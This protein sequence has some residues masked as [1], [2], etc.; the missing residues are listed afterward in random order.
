M[1]NEKVHFLWPLNCCNL[2]SNIL[3]GVPSHGI[4]Q[5]EQQQQQSSMS[6]YSPQD[7]AEG[8]D[9]G[10]GRA[11]AGSGLRF[12]TSGRF[13]D[14]VVPPEAGTNLAYLS[15]REANFLR[16]LKK[17]Q[18]QKAVDAAPEV[19]R[20]YHESSLYGQ[21]ALSLKVRTALRSGYLGLLIHSL[22]GIGAAL[23]GILY[24]YASYH[25]EDIP[26]WTSRAQNA[27]SIFFTFDYAL[28]LF[29][30]NVRMHYATSVGGIVDVLSII[31]L[32]LVFGWLY[33]LMHKVGI[34]GSNLEQRLLLLIVSTF[35]MVF[36][37][38]GL[39]QWVEL[40]SNGDYIEF[41]EC[42]Y[43]VWVTISTVGY[44]DVT[45]HS[46]WGR[47]VG[48]LTILLALV[49]LPYQLSNL[50]SLAATR[51]YGGKF[52]VNKVDNSQ[53]VIISG[54]ISY[55]TIDTFL[56]E[57]YR[58]THDKELQG[59]ID[60]THPL[61]TIILAPFR[62]SYQL[63][64]LVAR[65]NGLV[66][67]FEGTPIKQADLSRVSVRAA[68]AV[69]LLADS[70]AEDPAAEDS[71]QVVR[72]LSVFRYC[73]AASRI[74]VEV[75]QPETETSAVWGGIAGPSVE[76]VC[77]VKGLS[78]FLVNLFMSEVDLGFPDDHYMAEY[79]QSLF[80]E[81][82]PLLL[83]P[84]FHGLT[85]EE[86]AEFLMV[87]WGVVIFG[88]DTPVPD[89]TAREG[90]GKR[91]VLLYPQ[92]RRVAPRDVGLVII[93][94]LS[95][96]FQI[97]SFG[98]PNKLDACMQRLGCSR[99][100]VLQSAA[101]ETVLREVH[102]SWRG[103]KVPSSQSARELLS[104][105]A[106][107]SRSRGGAPPALNSP[108]SGV[109]ADML[110]DSLKSALVRASSS[111][112]LPPEPP[113]GGGGGPEVQPE[114]AEQ[115]TPHHVGA[116]EKQGNAGEAAHLEL[117]DHQQQGKR[118]ASMTR[119]VSIRVSSSGE[120]HER[121]EAAT[122]ESAID[123][124][125][126]WPPADK[127][128]RPYPFAL[129]QQAGKILANLEERRRNIGTEGRRA[130]PEAAAERLWAVGCGGGQQNEWP[131][132]LYY[133]LSTL[134]SHHFLRKP[135]VILHP[136]APTAQQWGYCG[137]FPDVF[138]VEGSPMHELDLLRAGILQA[139]KVVVVADAGNPKDSGSGVAAQGEEL[140]FPNNAYINDVQNMIIAANCEDLLPAGGHSK[141]LVEMQHSTS[142]LYLPPQLELSQNRIKE[143]DWEFDREPLLHFAPPFIEGKVFCS[144]RS[145]F[146]NRATKD[147]VEQLI[148]GGPAPDV[149]HQHG[150]RE[151]GSPEPARS[152]EQICV[153]SEFHGSTYIELFKYL[154]RE[155]GLLS[156]GLF[157]AAGTLD[158]PV[159]YVYTNPH[160]QVIV[161]RE[162]LV[163]VII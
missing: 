76:V 132:N 9:D 26:G 63:E 138:F 131:T 158:A 102:D 143:K 105:L 66:E 91:Q 61:R 136:H 89:E 98:T 1:V 139:L 125:M 129:T 30:E 3:G 152:L 117:Q 37:D 4:P 118:Q 82:H 151:D 44:G 20:T 101:I 115:T 39:V 19:L 119:R 100:A 150:A 11:G 64:G 144:S 104:R 97:S 122:L 71:A 137:M 33:P 145:M 116:D 141:V 84:A 134:R 109:T 15:E 69:Y 112:H 34:R 18:R 88:L 12:T 17:R 113:L 14:H 62:P 155:E 46:F 85:F 41:Y 110:Q 10:G 142:F 52:A 65:Y 128:T 75:L 2:V 156:L 107:E 54:S 157:R 108:S 59:Y 81:V 146:H 86:V 36:I 23:S 42:V 163:F 7:D 93:R 80:N 96:A 56:S 83:P 22:E 106:E 149:I 147:I 29:S 60:S 135:V 72:A 148:C 28:T 51:P 120:P 31:P 126:A 130:L 133:M 114:E 124:L 68:S 73:G 161:S 74:I 25:L 45:P 5:R 121:L 8:G 48:M 162:D 99:S 154:L 77:Y 127:K 58:L 67:F 140:K 47:L 103:A 123:R 32:I 50:V 53:Y 70:A 38:A 49:V 159:P 111:A 43:F 55:E 94:D 21:V 79:Q 13:G 92:G 40:R 35:G 95:I 6:S 24:I 160:H 90:K 57:F 78:T 153:P 16:R 87:E 27:I